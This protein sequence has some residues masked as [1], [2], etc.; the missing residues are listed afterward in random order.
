MEISASGNGGKVEN[1]MKIDGVVKS[2]FCV[3]P[4][5]IMDILKNAQIE[6]YRCFIVK[7]AQDLCFSEEMT[8]LIWYCLYDVK[9]EIR[10]TLYE[11]TEEYL[12]LLDTKK[13]IDESKSRNRYKNGYTEETYQKNGV[14]FKS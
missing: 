12:K 1:R 5:F 9:E 10:V 8:I 7:M 13:A 2:K 3:N 4:L 6:K 14:L 11:L